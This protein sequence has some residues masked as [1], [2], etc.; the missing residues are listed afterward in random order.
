LA[1][2]GEVRDQHLHFYFILNAYWQSLDFE[3]PKLNG[4]T[5]R[6]W[7]DTA[8]ESPEDIVPWEKAPRVKGETYRAAE[9]SVV[10]LYSGGQAKGTNAGTG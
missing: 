6:R 10:M 8:L 9:R 4:A 1:L 7:I 3:L 5:W 2:E